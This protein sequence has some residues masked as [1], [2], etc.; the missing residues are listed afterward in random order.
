MIQ[1]LSASGSFKTKKV[2]K[3]RFRT[4]DFPLKK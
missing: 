2:S 1:P 4:Y 3:I